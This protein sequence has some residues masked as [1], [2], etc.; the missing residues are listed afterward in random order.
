MLDSIINHLVTVIVNSDNDMINGI[1]LNE[2]NGALNHAPAL[3]NIEYQLNKYFRIPYISSGH[4]DPQDVIYD[5]TSYG[6]IV[7]ENMKLDDKCIFYIFLPDTLNNIQQEILI[8]IIDELKDYEVHLLRQN[9]EFFY[10]E[11]KEN[12]VNIKSKKLTFDLQKR[13]FIAKKDS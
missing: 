8:N 11:H 7:I 2:I 1:L 10:T 3:K 9:G 12:I 4:Y 13:Q 5:H 6:N